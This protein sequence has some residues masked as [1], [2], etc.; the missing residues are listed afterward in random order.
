[1]RRR[2]ALSLA[3]AGAL[4]AAAAPAADAGFTT[5][6]GLSGPPN[7]RDA[8]LQRARTAQSKI[9]RIGVPWS[10]IATARPANPADPADPAY[11]FTVLD[12]QI[13]DITAAGLRPL[14]TVQTAPAFAEGPGRS[15]SAPAGTWRPDPGA[16]GSFAQALARRYSG[17]FAGLPRV[18]YF[19]AWNE[20]NLSQYL[21]PQYSGRTP[22]GAQHYRRMLNAF[23]DG[24]KSAGRSNLVITGG[25]GPYGDRPGG[26]RTRPLA[27]WREVLC[28]KKR[29]RNRLAGAKCNP[30][31]RF[32]VLSH[33]AIN[34]SGSPRKSALHPDD[35][36]TADLGALRRVLRTAERKHK[37]AGGKRRH[38]IWVSEIWWESNPPDSFRGLPLAKQARYLEQTLYLLWKGGA[39]LVVNL[40]TGDPPY[41][42][43]HPLATADAG[44]YFA[45]GRP[46][47]ALTAFK[48]PFVTERSSKRTL[49]AWGKAPAGGRLTV[50]ARRGGGWRKVGGR[51]VGANR[52]FTLPLRVSGKAQLRAKVGGQT[53]LVWSQGG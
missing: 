50:E 16:Y 27:F 36:S 3:A 46:K 42:P 51:Q 20:P 32:D 17:G 8:W 39:K 11:N 29:K 5:G 10:L 49:R 26:Q 44:I 24:I 25:T 47:P 4:L 6:L 41:D 37:I 2:L 13:S 53:S 28:L 14:L 40:H 1:V 7:E 52:V 34:T 33:H 35:V 22:V 30:K 31:P 38:Q 9:I 21:N 15:G 43:N 18:R 23:Y 19:Q 45:D 48:F 12:D